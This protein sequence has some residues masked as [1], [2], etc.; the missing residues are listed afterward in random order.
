VQTQSDTTSGGRIAQPFGKYFLLER[1]GAGGMAEVFRA[2]VTGPEG[3]QRSLV[4]KRILPHLSQDSSFVGMFIDE[5][6][7]SSL[8]SHP[9]LVQIFEFGK[10]NESFFIAMEHVHGRTLAAVQTKLA[11]AGRLAPIAATMEIG[12]QICAGLHYAHSLQSGDGKNLGIVHRDISPSNLML[13]FHGGVKILDF[14]IARVAEGLRQSRTHIGEMKGKISYMAPEQILLEEIDHRADIFAVGIVLHEMLTGRR[15]FRATSDYAAS[16]MVLD[17]PIPVP[18]TVNPAVPQGLDR[19]VMRALERDRNARYASAGEMASELEQLIL[20]TRVSPHEHQ[21]LLH[22]LFPNE[23]SQK[24]ELEV[25]VSA[26][27]V[28]AEPAPPASEQITS[29]LASKSRARGT[30]SISKSQPAGGES[31]AVEMGSYDAA[32]RPLQQRAPQGRAKWIAIG[33]AAIG[34]AVAVPIALLRKPAEP[35]AAP[36]AAAPAPTAV[37]APARPAAPSQVRFSLDS[38]P[39]DA[40]V[41]RVD[42][43]EVMGRTPLTVMI[44]Q[45]AAMISFRFDKPGFDSS[46]Y[47]I[48]P[49]LDKAVHVDLTPVPAA[50]AAAAPAAVAHAAPAR[51]A[52]G[53]HGAAAPAPA[54]AEQCY[55]TIGSFPWAQLWIDGHDSGQHTPVVHFP[56]PCGSHKV[57]LKRADLQVNQA[58]EITLA[59]GKEFKHNYQLAHTDFDD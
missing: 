3:F 42:T 43:G 13:A 49:D 32:G 19:V 57:N 41:T 54:A 53:K 56:I 4:I 39:Q 45:S 8:L 24:T 38:N 10:V 30:G 7:L 23:I 11:G 21:K 6:K 40:E 52:H 35:P 37:A 12:R 16:R 18:S 50:H 36:I 22:E 34:V 44:P 29:Q 1:I 20:E 58:V 46:F 14:G 33:A 9:N 55:A 5:A 47:K 17:H 2:I 25:P 15:L 51:A 31:Y 48:I 28:A 59:A 26:V 27:S